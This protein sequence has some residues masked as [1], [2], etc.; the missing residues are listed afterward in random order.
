MSLGGDQR[1]EA[2]IVDRYQVTHYVD[3]DNMEGYVESLSNTY[4]LEFGAGRVDERRLNS[5]DAIG[6]ELESNDT[7]TGAFVEVQ[8]ALGNAYMDIARH[9]SEEGN[10]GASRYSAKYDLDGR[11]VICSRILEGIINVAGNPNNKLRNRAYRAI[12]ENMAD[13]WRRCDDLL[14]T[15]FNMGD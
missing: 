7:I 10:G 12:S 15:G 4:Y 2:N 6:E 8:S 13:V 1:R 11:N 14:N 9:G 3:V 5:W